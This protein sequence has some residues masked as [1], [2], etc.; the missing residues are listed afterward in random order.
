MKKVTK[1]ATECSKANPRKVIP[2]SVYPARST[3]PL[4]TLSERMP[5]GIE[6]G[7][8]HDVEQA[9][10]P[11]GYGHCGPFLHQIAEEVTGPQYE[12]QEV[13]FPSANT[14]ATNTKY[15][16]SI[17]SARKLRPRPLL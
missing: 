11:N 13:K 3:L 9:V 16:S 1:A 12:N 8:V 15:F 6:E 2:K 14:V 10:E 5:T 4:P 7:C 17:G